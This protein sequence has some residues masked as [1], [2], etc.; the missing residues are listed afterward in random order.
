MVLS[1]QNGDSTYPVKGNANQESVDCIEKRFGAFRR[2]TDATIPKFKA[3]QSKALEFAHLIDELCPHSQE[4][5]TALTHLATVKMQANAAI[6]LH[7]C[8]EGPL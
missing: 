3:I 5:A 2:P 8:D 4:K 6:A 1:E 7:E